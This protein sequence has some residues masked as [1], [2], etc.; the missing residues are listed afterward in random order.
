MWSRMGLE[1]QE[2]KLVLNKGGACG[3]WGT[4]REGG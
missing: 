4:R 3:A 1:L 2:T